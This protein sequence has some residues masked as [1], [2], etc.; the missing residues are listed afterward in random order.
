MGHMAHVLLLRQT[1]RAAV[2]ARAADTCGMFATRQRLLQMLPCV[3]SRG[4]GSAARESMSSFPRCA[5]ERGT[6]RRDEGSTVFE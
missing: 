6:W 1:P 3:L 4:H 5:E 2:L